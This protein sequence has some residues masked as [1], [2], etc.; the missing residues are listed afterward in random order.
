MKNLPRDR[1]GMCSIKSELKRKCVMGQQK[2]EV[3]FNV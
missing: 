2:T 1:V 3:G